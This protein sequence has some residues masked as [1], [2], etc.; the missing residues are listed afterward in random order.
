MKELAEGEKNLT[1][2][3]QLKKLTLSS[4]PIKAD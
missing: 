2:E 1:L 4:N 3:A